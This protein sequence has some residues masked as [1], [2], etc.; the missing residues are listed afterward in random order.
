MTTEKTFM[1]VKFDHNPI[2]DRDAMQDRAERGLNTPIA[3][4][5]GLRATWS[6]MD[7]KEK[8]IEYDHLTL[9]A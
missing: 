1:G 9:E 7:D 6:N 3:Y 2:K 4:W 8:D 5:R